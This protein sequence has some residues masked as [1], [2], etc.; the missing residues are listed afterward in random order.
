MRDMEIRGAGNILGTRQHGFISAVGFELYIKLLQEAVDEIKG[1]ETE[2]VK[3]PETRLE[4]PLQAYLPTEYIADGT[5][6]IAVYQEM[7]SVKA[8]DD[9]LEMEKSLSDR[10]G[11]LPD[12]VRSL[13]LMIQLKLLGQSAGCSR[14]AI[15]KEGN[16]LLYI[17]GDQETAKERIRLFFES[18]EYH[19]E[20]IYDAQVQLKTTLL[21][22]TTTERALETASI[23][24]QAVRK[25]T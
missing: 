14:V 4:I 3:L 25:A 2:A 13:I 9:L 8:V 17:E 12:S 15:N 23:L 22:A 7:S 6:R 20:V 10:F 24:E 21:S 5:T 18:S 11:P 1:G 16:L 19:F